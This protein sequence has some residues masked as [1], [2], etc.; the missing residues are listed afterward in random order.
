MPCREWQLPMP[1]QLECDRM[2][3]PGML[4]IKWQGCRHGFMSR[5]SQHPGAG[6]AITSLPPLPSFTLALTSPLVDVVLEPAS[7][8]FPCR[9]QTAHGSLGPTGKS[10]SSAYPWRPL[11]L[12]LQL[13]P[14][15]CFGH[16]TCLRTPLSSTLTL[17]HLPAHIHPDSGFLLFQSCLS[18][19]FNF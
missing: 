8:N 12:H 15:A 1:A 5:R 2:I 19:F 9:S 14:L 11:W 18:F 3:L 7:D 13:F 4:G 10:L 16:R 17:P 6:C